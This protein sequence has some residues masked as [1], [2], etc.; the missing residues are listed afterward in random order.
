MTVEVRGVDLAVD[1]SGTGTAVLWGH[2]LTSSMA[3][4]AQIG[5]L[6]P[7]LPEHGFRLVRY[8][9]R[10]H[11]DSTG[12]TDPGDYGYPELARDQLALA[13][14]LGID[15]FVSG[16]A[17]MGTGTAL[18]AA[19]QA[20]ARVL[21]LV[22]VI[23]PTGWEGREERGG[24]YQDAGRLVDEA[25]IEALIA[26]AE[27][28]PVAPV[29]APFAEMLKDSVRAR[30]EPFDPAVLSAV[31]RGVGASDL[32][33][34]EAIATIAAPTLILAWEGDPVHPSSSAEAL[35]DLI[36]GAELVLASSLREVTRWPHLSRG[37]L[38][39]VLA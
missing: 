28:E 23:P 35:A 3:A 36:P 12:T 27:A 39:R 13:D 32:P 25:G 1:E 18:H 31:L 34:R 20:P 7:D 30:Y 8:D 14:A 17:S 22:L 29:F 2:G 37:F 33:A 16:G 21:G 11:G 5:L 38:D 4:E 15:R 9:A 6:T 10:G 19:V 24:W 26:M